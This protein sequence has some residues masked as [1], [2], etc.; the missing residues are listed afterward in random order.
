M[1]VEFTHMLKKASPPIFSFD[2]VP[3]EYLAPSWGDLERACIDVAKQVRKNGISFDVIVTLAKG[4]WPMTRSLSDMTGI[5]EIA[6][7]GVKFYVGVN[8]RADKPVIYQDLPIDVKGKRVLLFDD[9]ADTGGSLEFVGQLLQDRGA[10][11]VKTA[12]LYYKPHSVINPDY[13]SQTT[14]AWII[15]PSEIVEMSQLLSDNW[16]KAGIDETEMKRRFKMMGFAKTLD[17]LS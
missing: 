13:Y 14:T 17:R 11:L 4:G 3:A 8:Q 1:V 2:Q 5:E 12:T 16:L 7:I 10:R 9:I 6:S 15:T